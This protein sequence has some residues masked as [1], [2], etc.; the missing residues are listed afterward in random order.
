MDYTNFTSYQ[1]TSLK[2]TVCAGTGYPVGGTRKKFLV[3]S[4]AVA[5]PTYHH[6]GGCLF[7]ATPWPI[8]PIP[9]LFH[10]VAYKLTP[11]V[12]DSP[13]SEYSSLGMDKIGHGVATNKHPPQ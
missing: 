5:A 9:R 7:V 10:E 8:L 6:C 4:V 3:C 12:S 11:M 2:P 1:L 13:L